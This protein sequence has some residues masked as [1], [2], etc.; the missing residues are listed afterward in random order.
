MK[1]YVKYPN[2]N[3]RMNYSPIEGMLQMILIEAKLEDRFN[4]FLYLDWENN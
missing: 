1:C 2:L 4:S 3:L